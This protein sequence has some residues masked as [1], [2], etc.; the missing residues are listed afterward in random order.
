MGE[1]ML[2]IDDTRIK[3]ADA[4]PLIGKSIRVAQQM[5]EAGE[6]PG[7]IKIR[8]EWTFSLAKLRAW[9]DELENEQCRKRTV[10][11]EAGRRVRPHATHNGSGAKATAGPSRPAFASAAASADGPY[12]QAMSKLLKIGLEKKSRR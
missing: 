10:V 7:A 4:L 12:E 8:G 9:L 6:I 2:R 3:M 11:A 1:P 5:A